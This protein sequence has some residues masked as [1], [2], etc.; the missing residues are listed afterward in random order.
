MFVNILQTSYVKTHFN[1]ADLL[2][3]ILLNQQLHH[4]F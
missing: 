3:L 2:I 4:P 1:L